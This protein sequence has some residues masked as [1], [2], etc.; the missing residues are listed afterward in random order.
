M[1]KVGAT[2]RRLFMPIR[3]AI[4]GPAHPKVRHRREQN[5]AP[6][7]PMTTGP[8]P[9]TAAYMPPQQQSFQPAPPPMGMMP[10]QGMAQSMPQPVM[11]QP[12]PNQL[13][14]MDFS[15]PPQPIKAIDAQATANAANAVAMANK[16]VADLEKEPAD[17]EL[18][19]AEAE[20]ARLEKELEELG[21]E[22]EAPEGE[23]LGEDDAEDEE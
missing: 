10:Q 3:D 19:A 5:F 22:P 20:M 1:W 7:A 2:I 6:Q 17:D 21:D 9:G 8:A 4:F 11:P 12:T 13:Q 15:R 16:F 18:A 23:D 14:S